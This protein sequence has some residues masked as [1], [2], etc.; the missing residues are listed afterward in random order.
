MSQGNPR[1]DLKEHDDEGK[2]SRR[3]A[4]LR[5]G[6]ERDQE[7]RR[8]YH[9]TEDEGRHDRDAVTLRQREDR[10]RANK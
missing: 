6:T 9:G 8:R 5:E 10:E 7:T 3:D 2:E 4:D 1:R